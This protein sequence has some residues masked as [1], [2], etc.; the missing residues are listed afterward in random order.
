MGEVVG[1][2]LPADRDVVGHA[3]RTVAAPRRA[4]TGTIRDTPDRNDCAGI[5]ARSFTAAALLRLRVRDKGIPS[6]AM[7]A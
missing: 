5:Q 2:L 6:G 1:G 3:R 4:R 7:P